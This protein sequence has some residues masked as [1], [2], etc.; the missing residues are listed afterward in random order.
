MTLTKAIIAE[1]LSKK[2]SYTNMNSLEMLDSLLEIMKQTLE[3]GE[4]VLISGFGKFSVKKKRE[5]IGRNLQNGQPM[6]IAPKKVLTFKCSGKL[7]D[8]INGKK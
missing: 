8:R 5:R 3:S 1:A 4:D 7:R 6:M 2:M